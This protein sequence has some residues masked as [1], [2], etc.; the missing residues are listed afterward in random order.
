MTQAQLAA[1]SGVSAKSIYLFE[2]GKA[3]AKSWQ[4]VNLAVALD[5]PAHTLLLDQ[6]IEQPSGGSV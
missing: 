4:L 6:P 2:S 5:V 3:Y 1:A